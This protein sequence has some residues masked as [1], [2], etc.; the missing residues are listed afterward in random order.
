MGQIRNIDSASPS[1]TE[2]LV[3]CRKK[4]H[5]AQKL[6]FERYAGLVLTTCRRYSTS[7]YPPKDLLQDTFIKV[8]EKIHQFDENK[9]KFKSWIT[10]IAINLALNSIRDRKIKIVGYE[11]EMEQPNENE[12][13]SADL[14][15]EKILAI[16][17]KLPMGYKTVFNL[18]AIDGF[19]H[20]E[21]ADKLNISLSTSKSQL[22]KA[23]RA[24]QL[25]ITAIKKGNYGGIR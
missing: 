14:S 17:D 6:L 2:L 22:F 25:E 4:D 19:S 23:K 13:L 1:L 10:R 20:Q 16:I 21:I 7:Y 9:G 12:K 15:E 24:L 5:V 8:F 3:G 18:Y 11:M